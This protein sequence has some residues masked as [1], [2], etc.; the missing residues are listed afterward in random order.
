MGQLCLKRKKP[1]FVF[2]LPTE[3]AEGNQKLIRAGALALDPTD[4]MAGLLAAEIPQD[5]DGEQLRL[6]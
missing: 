1:L 4:P 6:L 5:P 3:V 2:D